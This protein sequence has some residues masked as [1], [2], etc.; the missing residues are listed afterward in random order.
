MNPAGAPCAK[1]APIG[2]LAIADDAN[3]TLSFLNQLI[4]MTPIFFYVR[5]GSATELPDRYAF[6]AKLT[7]PPDTHAAPQ[8]CSTLRP[9]RP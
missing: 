1:L 9:P 8:F 5:L 3:K 6:L 4:P 7:S 2:T